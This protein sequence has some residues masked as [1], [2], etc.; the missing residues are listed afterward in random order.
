MKDKKNRKYIKLTFSKSTRSLQYSSVTIIPGG[1]EVKDDLRNQIIVQ[2]PVWAYFKT[3]EEVTDYFIKRHTPIRVWVQTID[4]K[5]Y[6]EV[7][8]V[9]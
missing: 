2:L 5:K 8:V 4:R 1:R 9:E 3:S 6:Y 7:T